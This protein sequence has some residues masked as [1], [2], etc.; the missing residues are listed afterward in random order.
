MLW[1]VVQISVTLICTISYGYLQ[2]TLTVDPTA[3][4]IKTLGKL[5]LSYLLASLMVSPFVMGLGP[6]V[7]KWTGRP[8]RWGK[9]MIWRKRWGLTAFAFGVGHLLAYGVLD[10]ELVWEDLWEDVFKRPFM[11]YGRVSLLILT[12][13]A[14]TSLKSI[15]RKIPKL[16]PKLHKGVYIALILGVIHYYQS[17]KKDVTLPVFY[18]VL[19]GLLIYWRL[20]RLYQKHNAV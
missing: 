4:A 18:A 5:C 14:V 10:K 17:V 11:M 13:L 15:Q 3:F 20:H 19:S 12:I 9:W 7:A 1:L 8:S 6:L 16:W 2:G